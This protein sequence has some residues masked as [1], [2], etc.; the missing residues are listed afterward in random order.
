MKTQYALCIVFTKDKPGVT[1]IETIMFHGSIEHPE[2]TDPKK[3]FDKDKAVD[4]ALKGS[5][6]TIELLK[7][8]HTYFLSNHVIL[9]A[10]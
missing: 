3:V 4:D 2:K 9:P 6:K 8:G 10:L 5:K 7:S 1:R